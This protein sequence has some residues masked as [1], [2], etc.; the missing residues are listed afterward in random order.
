[1]ADMAV[2][3]VGRRSYDTGGCCS[4]IL[5]T[6]KGYLA[7]APAIFLT[8]SCYVVLIL[9]CF[10]ELINKEFKGDCELDVALYQ[11]S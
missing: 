11:D 3:G 4:A 1:M 6:M 10:I 5:I 9:A 8:H 2:A 7:S